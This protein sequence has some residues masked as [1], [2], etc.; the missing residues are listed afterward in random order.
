[1]LNPYEPT[2]HPR[3]TPVT[4][5]ISELP[6]IDFKGGPRA[7]WLVGYVVGLSVGG[8]LA[9]LMKLDVPGPSFWVSLCLFL[10]VGFWVSISM[11]SALLP[12]FSR[13]AAGRLTVALAVSLL[14]TITFLPVMFSVLLLLAMLGLFAWINAIPGPLIV[15]LGVFAATSVFA[16][17]VRVFAEHL[18][19]DLRESMLKKLST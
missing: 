6:K 19:K 1:M 2:L 7:V 5:S 11:V 16:F 3:E 17:W 9:L 10:G 18:R 8:A 12:E 14:A 4:E 15:A 13:D